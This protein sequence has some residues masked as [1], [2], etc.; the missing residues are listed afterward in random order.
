LS[1]STGVSLGFRAFGFRR[2]DHDLAVILPHLEEIEEL[3]AGVFRGT[4]DSEGATKL[5]APPRPSMF[6]MLMPAV[7]DARVRVTLF[8]RG[9]Q[10]ARYRVVGE[11]SSPG[12]TIPVDYIRELRDIGT[13][14]IDVPPEVRR[15][16]GETVRDEPDSP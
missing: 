9:G 6:V 12:G 10:L 15:K 2:P 7:V 5:M 13:T 4:L 1:K 16:F 14:V 3:R 8:V 11:R